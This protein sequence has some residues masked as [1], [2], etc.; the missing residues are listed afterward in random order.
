M[1]T[2]LFDIIFKHLTIILLALTSSACASRL[3]S[4]ISDSAVPSPALAQVRTDSETY[5]G[6]TVRW[7]GNITRVENRRD[8]T[9]VEVVEHPLY[10]N[11]RPKTGNASGG[12]FIAQ[13]P[14][15]LDPAIYA[16]GRQITVIGTLETPIQR[17]IG[18][19]PYTF[20]VVAVNQ[21]QLW[22]EPA[23]PAVIY[24]DP[25]YYPYWHSPFYRHYW[26]H[27]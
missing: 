19:H 18:E 21:H 1:T 2:A 20:A 15:F 17:P 23:E 26:R 14:G 10:R 11:G 13:I 27:Y 25:F 7:G 8:E 12:R 16:P 3:Y 5:L 4:P 22:E 9:W 6:M 24:Y